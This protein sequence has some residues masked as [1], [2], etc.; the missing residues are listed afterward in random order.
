MFVAIIIVKMGFVI[1]WD[2]VKV[3]LDIALLADKLNEYSKI[4]T[5]QPGVLTV[6]S[7]R[8]RNAGSFRFIDIDAGLKAYSVRQANTAVTRI[9]SALKKY[10]NTIDTV[11]VH[12]THEFPKVISIFIPTDEG[13]KQIS[14]HFGKSSHFTHLKY[15]RETG[16]Y[17]DLKTEINP[18]HDEDE[19]RGIKLAEYIIDKGA[20]LQQSLLL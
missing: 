7:I 11:F 6:R 12:F 10:D 8:G 18:Y 16:E 15:D 4:I 1:L 5:R 9:E 17:S 19:H 14:T 13:G 2:N 20:D 3:L